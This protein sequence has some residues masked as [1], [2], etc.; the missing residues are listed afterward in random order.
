MWIL[1]NNI[2]NTS[3]IR[4]SEQQ[5][6]DCDDSDDGCDGGDTPTA[7]A[8]IIGAGGLE[9]ESTYPYTAKDGKCKFDNKNVVAKISKWKYACTSKD[10]KTLQNN[11]ATW[12]PLSI[13]VDAEYWQYYQ[14]G[15]MSAWDCAWINS[16][17]HCVEL[18]GYDTT[19]K[20][21]YWIVRNSWGTRWG[22]NGYIYLSMFQNTCGMTE[23]ST[24]SIV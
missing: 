21:P 16:L 7:Y 20:A 17:D 13:C 14:S 12:G 5:V 18:V 6:V 23:E 1:A 10:E 8:Y 24:T 19:A 22:I 2:T 4:L 15:V 3:S 11:L 9:S